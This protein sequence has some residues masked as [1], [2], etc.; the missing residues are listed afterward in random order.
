M[1]RFVFVDMRDDVKWVVEMGIR[2]GL[3]VRHMC[4][5]DQ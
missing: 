1:L 2:G 5:D 3:T 4:Y